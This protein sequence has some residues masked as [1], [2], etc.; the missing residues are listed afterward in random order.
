MGEK[1]V[2]FIDAGPIM[3]NV[4]VCTAAEL[5]DRSANIW[6]ICMQLLRNNLHA[7]IEAAWRK[8][9]YDT[10]IRLTYVRGASSKHEP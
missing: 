2:S 5:E 4:V 6:I 7:L 8:L 1:D 10:F 3:L 9:V